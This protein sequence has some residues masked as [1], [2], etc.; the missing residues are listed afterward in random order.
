MTFTPHTIDRELDLEL[1]REVPVSPEAVYAAWTTPASLVEWFAPR[2]YS[3]PLVEIDLRPGGGFRTV[4]NDPDGQEIMDSTGCYLEVVPDER[5]VWT[6]ALTVGYRPQADDMPFTAILEFRPDGSG[7]CTYRAIAMHQDAAGADQHREMG[8]HE[9][10]GTVVD[11]MV[12]H[13]LAP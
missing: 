12:E 2:P 3:V 4:M 8:F 7:G 1:I 10:W 6:S 9:G 11:Q 5:L 13:L